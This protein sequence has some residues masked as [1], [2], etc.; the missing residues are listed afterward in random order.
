MWLANYEKN[1]MRMGHQPMSGASEIPMIWICKI[2][3]AF[4]LV[5]SGIHASMAML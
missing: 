1:F 5:M 4:P 2:F 3:F